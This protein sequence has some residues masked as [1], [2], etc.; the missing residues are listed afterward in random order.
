MAQHSHA[1]RRQSLTQSLA[2]ATIGFRLDVDGRKALQARANEAGVSP[3]V[4][5][6]AIVE[7]VLETGGSLAEL[8]AIYREVVELRREVSELRIAF[9][10]ATAVLLVSAGRTTAEAAKE[11]VEKNLHKK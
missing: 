2:P 5:A 8:I 1:Q 6:R 7:Q 4:I 10:T 9:S 3:H 11:W